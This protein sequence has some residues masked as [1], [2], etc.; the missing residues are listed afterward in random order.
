[1]ATQ[2][3]AVGTNEGVVVM[4]DLK[5]AIRL[6]VLEGH[7]KPITTCSFSTDGR[8]LVTLS[9][10]ESLVLVWKVGSSFSSFFN[11]GAPP[12]QGHGGSQPF[13]TLNFNVGADGKLVPLFFLKKRNEG[14]MQFL[15]SGVIF[16]E[17]DDGRNIGFSSRW[18]D[19]WSQRKSK[20]T[21]ERL[22]LQHVRNLFF[23]IFITFCS[24]V[25]LL[26]FLYSTSKLYFCGGNNSSR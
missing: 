10:G 12:S 4:Y 17:H 22:D 6:Y 23:D 1:M 25:L 7:T 21:T 11:P 2:K 3:L 14:C 26:R 19:R 5:T 18:M 24:T 9:L 16:R 15:I 8:R 20:N 13:K